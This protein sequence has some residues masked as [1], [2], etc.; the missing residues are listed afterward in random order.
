MTVALRF[1]EVCGAAFQ[2]RKQARYCSGSCRQQAYRIRE[3]GGAPGANGRWLPLPFYEDDLTT[4]YQGDCIEIL[5]ALR[6]AKVIIAD[7]PYM[8]ASA[9]TPQTKGYGDKL[10]N[11]RWYQSL[12][13]SSA[14]ALNLSGGALW[15]FNYWRSFSTL[16]MAA[17]Q[18]NW[19][20]ESLLVWNKNWIG[21][22]TMVG[23]RQSYEL[24]ALFAHGDFAIKDRSLRDIWTVPWSATKPHGHPAEKPEDLMVQLLEASGA[25]AGDLVID[26][27]T[28]SGT[29]LAA[30]RKMGIKSIGIETERKWLEVACSRICQQTLDFARPFG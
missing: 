12:L 17:A 3:K 19:P 8:M 10:N 15:V 1:C 6:D 28:G 14:L 4:L 11:S 13:E 30:A 20:I 24:C 5:P 25:A 16:D 23:L 21:P 2:A 22:G 27:C 26:P 9:S 29:V 7:P 18:A